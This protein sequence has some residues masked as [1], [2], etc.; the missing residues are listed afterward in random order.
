[1]ELEQLINLLAQRMTGQESSHLTEMVLETLK[2]E[3][4]PDYSWPGNVRE[5]EQAVRRILLTRHYGGDTTLTNPDPADEFMQKFKTGGLEAQELLS[6]Y[7][8]L[9]FNRFGTYEEV[10]RRT[11]LDRRTVKKYISSNL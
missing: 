6:Q 11:K 4:P 10:A 7:C 3:L 2:R 5:L 9:L 8:T 1:M